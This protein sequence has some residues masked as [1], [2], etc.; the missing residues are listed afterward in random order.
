VVVRFMVDELICNV[1]HTCREVR[2]ICGQFRV[3]AGLV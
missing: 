1:R 3:A 2:A